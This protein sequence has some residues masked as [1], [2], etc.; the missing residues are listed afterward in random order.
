MNVGLQSGYIFSQRCPLQRNRMETF[1][2]FGY[3]QAI[4]IRWKMQS[5]ESGLFSL[6]TYGINP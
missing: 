4:S 6:R 3:R 1:P 5:R 2:L